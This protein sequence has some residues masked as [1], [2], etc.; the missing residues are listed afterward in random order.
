MKISKGWQVALA[1]MGINFLGG[2]CYTW[3]IFGRGLTR[4][5]GWTQAQAS[6]P[7]T[8]FIFCYAICMIIAGG[9][10]DRIG[11]RRTIAAGGVLLGSSFILAS[12]FKM[13]VVV[14]V[15]WG[16]FFG[17]GLAC[18]FASATP[19]AIKWF[20]PERRGLV[21]GVVVGGMGL[22]ALVMSPLV[23]SLTGKGVSFAFLVSGL[24]LGTGI[25]LLSRLVSNPPLAGTVA[26][27][28]EK[29][30]NR[31]EVL[32][33]RPFYF[34]WIMFLLTT[35]AGLTFATHLDRITRV[36]ASYEKG[37]LMVS[38]FALFNAA[39]RPIGG[40]LSDL[41]GRVRAMTV[42]FIVMTCTLLF[43]IKAVN[44]LFLAI[45][46]AFL[47]LTYGGVFSLFPAAAASLFGDK[48]RT[49]D[50]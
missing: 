21:V 47:G 38:L 49:G 17:A 41:L 36:H 27:S 26:S 24:V 3:S 1:G 9:V 31:F 12:F 34:L 32:H 22:S 40:F 45:A 28:K 39:G 10:Q 50:S 44:P 11:P 6:L 46:V 15:V 37:Y 14:A 5:F 7:Y 2:I 48:N 23:N 20:P 29:V 13:P 30:S 16:S 25:V 33:L 35:A 4:E 43:L 42:T 18:C 8:V 19:A